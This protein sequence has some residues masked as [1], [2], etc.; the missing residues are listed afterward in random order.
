MKKLLAVALILCSIKGFSQSNIDIDRENFFR[1]GFKGG[2]NINKIA[3]NSYNQGFNF[4]YQLGGFAQFN[5]SN[6]FGLQPEINFVQSS[7]EF[8]NEPSDIYN[9]LFYSGSQ[10][11][12]TL[13]YLEIPLLL[14]INVGVSKHV[15]LQIGPSY[16]RLLSKT[17]DNLRSH[18]DSLNYTTSDW[19]AI[20][21]LW[22][23][24]PFVNF[25]ARYKIGL[26]DI[27]NSA[28]KPETWTSQAI[29]IFAGITF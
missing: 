6:R 13:S 11:T 27:N 3:G 26:S 4:N 2:V 23:Q 19:S 12:A 22:I 10:K 1:F 15:K 7:S 16:G 18:S 24:L 21:G 29:Q 17:I 9:D 20:G 5:F 25:G 28:L 14:N 8:S